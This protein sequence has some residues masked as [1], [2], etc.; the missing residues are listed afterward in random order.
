MS[1]ASDS[2][3]RGPTTVPPRILPRRSTTMR[4]IPPGCCSVT[5]RSVSPWRIMDV[6]R[7]FPEASVT[8]TAASSGE[9]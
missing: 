6:V 5:A 8:P 1:S 7:P 9:V 4:V 3:A 2:P